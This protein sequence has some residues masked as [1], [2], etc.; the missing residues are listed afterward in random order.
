MEVSKQLQA[1]LLLPGTVLVVIPSLIVYFTGLDSKGLWRSCPATQFVLPI[2]GLIL[3]GLGLSL[4][5]ATIRL[6]GTVGK[7]TLAP[8]S[9]PKRLVVRGIYRRVRNP[10]ISGVLLVSL[11]EALLTASPP[12]L[13]LFGAALLLNVVYIPMAEEP[14]LVRRFGED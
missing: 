11:G 2:F 8:W 4:M 1:I 13:C 6:F 12:L 9:P 3:I 7:G 10:M 5:V 14:G